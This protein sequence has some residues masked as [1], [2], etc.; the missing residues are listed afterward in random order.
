MAC[1][2]RF[3]T[4]KP[5]D[6]TLT[7]TFLLTAPSEAAHLAVIPLMLILYLGLLI[8]VPWLRMQGYHVPALDACTRTASLDAH[9]ARVVLSYQPVSNAQ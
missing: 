8:Q 7:G 1:A 5:L 9:A 4:A 6:L 3:L 2:G